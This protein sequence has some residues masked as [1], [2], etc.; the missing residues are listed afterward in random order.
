MPHS[1]IKSQV[2]DETQILTWTWKR[3]RRWQTLSNTDRRSA[4]RLLTNTCRNLNESNS[5]KCK[6]VTWSWLAVLLMA[7]DRHTPRCTCT[8]SGVTIGGSAGSRNRSPRP[9][10]APDRGHSLFYLQDAKNQD[11]EETEIRSFAFSTSFLFA[12][13]YQDSSVYYVTTC[14]KL[15]ANILGRNIYV[16]FKFFCVRS[17][18]CFVCAHARTA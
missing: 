15:C 3:E 4:S 2:A 5:S 6:Y 10:G 13:F 1:T 16:R 8:C 17:S 11:S 9:L 7:I 12:T 18:H 14:M